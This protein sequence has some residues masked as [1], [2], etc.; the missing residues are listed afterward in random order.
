MPLRILFV[1][2]RYLIRG[3][4][5][6]STDAEARLLRARGHEVGV[7]EETN[8]RIADLSGVHAAVR[9]VWSAEVYNALRRQLRAQ[10]YDLVHVQNFFP[11]IS[12]AAHHAAKA[13]GVPVVQSVRNYRLLCPAATL[14]RAGGACEDCL[15]RAAPWPG[16]L[17]GC[18]RGSRS[19][20]AAIAAMV[21]AHRML[22][23]WQRKVEV[24]VAVSRFARDKLVEGGLPGDRIAIKPNFV[25]D[26][27]GPGNGRGDYALYVGRL[28]PEKGLATML[29]AWQRLKR[30]FP[31]KIVGAGPL[32]N[33][34]QTAAA[35][36][37]WI[38]SLGPLPLQQTREIMAKARFLIC[39][40]EWYE[41]FGRVVIE[42]FSRGV[43]V[44]A[45]AI[46]ALEEL[47]DHERT[48]RL[49][50]SGDPEDL[51]GQAEWLLGHDLATM[52][53]AA[54]EQFERHYTAEK[55][56]ALLMSI[57]R[58]AIDTCLSPAVPPRSISTRSRFSALAIR[59]RI[60]QQA[61][62]DWADRG[63][64]QHP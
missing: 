8:A 34:V 33:V 3:G 13:E 11:L 26:D 36:S 50:R 32:A 54:R 21:A 10:R 58:R 27:A 53:R 1:H 64:S 20:S 46:G 31:L 63:R 55:N 22:R 52:R 12:P 47:V 9:A 44:L 56:Y 17:H 2:N 43:P 6:V 15:G 51:A 24:F 7:Y 41:P 28:A 19:A 38:E 45:A 29:Q 48:G 4:E 25:D 59:M 23:T 5:D 39:P 49:F 42:A 18:Y 60:S 57:Y 40:S 37:P 62:Y 35:A 61:S 16:I 14:F 30:P